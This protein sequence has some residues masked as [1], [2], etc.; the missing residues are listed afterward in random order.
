MQ[1]FIVGS[2]FY[3]AQILDRCRLNKQIIEAHQILSAIEG[4]SSAWKNHPVV[5]SYSCHRHWLE[6]YTLCLENYYNNNFKDSRFYSRLANNIKPKFH[7]KSYFDQMKRR[8]YTKDPLYYKQW[9]TLG[10]SEVNWYYVGDQ[11]L[12]YQNG[13]RL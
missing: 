11:W 2:P 7:I 4:K 13:K 8:L 10:I 6:Y 1:V 3:T 5:L 12:K 9:A